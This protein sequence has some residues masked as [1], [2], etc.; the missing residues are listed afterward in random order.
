M[1]EWKVDAWY[2]VVR[3]KSC[4]VQFAFQRD[5]ETDE[6]IYFTDRGE[7]VLTCP[8]CHLPLAYSGEQVER[9]QAK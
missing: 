3:C 7:M 4:G 1:L 9:F 6:A 8:D 5:G 2:L